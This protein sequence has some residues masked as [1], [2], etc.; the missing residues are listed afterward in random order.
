MKR[1]LIVSNMY[2]SAEKP[3]SGVFVKNQYE[4]L[5]T[6]AEG[7]AQVDLFAMPRKFTGPVGTIAKYVA[8]VLRFL[9]RFFARYD[10]I[11]VHYFVPLFF[12]AWVYGLLR[13]RTRIVVTFHGTDASVK[14]RKPL[15]RGLARRAIRRADVVIAVGEDLADNLEQNLGRGADFVLPA[16]VDRSMFYREPGAAKRW[17]FVFVGSFLER[18][19]LLEFLAVAEGFGN[20]RRF[21]AVGS[22]P[23]ESVIAAHREPEVE[24]Q[25]NLTQDEIRGVMNQSRFLLFPS[26]QEAYGLVVTEAMYCGT[27]PIVSPIESLAGRVDHGRNGFVSAGMAADDFVAAA[28][29]ADGLSEREYAA[30]SAA[31]EASGAEA[32][33]ESVCRRLLAIYG[34]SD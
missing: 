22:G 32:A 8:A 30:M 13:P 28:R 24:V 26:H 4:C 19:G 12:V 18:K 3:Y 5:K 17:D 6:L 20:D 31:A 34:V 23:L 29:V 9:P 15:M 11:H 33:L 7:R 1:I 16:G 21:C 25:A 14:L 27:P 10:V 2:P